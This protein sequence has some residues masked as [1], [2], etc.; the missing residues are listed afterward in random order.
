MTDTENPLV[1]EIRSC[2]G[3]KPCKC[4]LAH[5][6]V[7]LLTFEINGSLEICQWILRGFR[8][9]NRNMKM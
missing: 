3:K 8:R 7:Y 9:V 6:A 5:V 2:I 4:R 1:T